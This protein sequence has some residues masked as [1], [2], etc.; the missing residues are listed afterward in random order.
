MDNEKKKRKPKIKN[1]LTEL[2]QKP[3]SDTKKKELI[4]I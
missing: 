1:C 4:K 2:T 3:E